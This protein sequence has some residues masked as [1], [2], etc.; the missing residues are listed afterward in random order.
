V[1]EVEFMQLLLPQQQE[2]LT[3]A[4]VVADSLMAYNLQLAAVQ[5]LSS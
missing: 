2:Q 1:V 4:V 3:Q 5:E